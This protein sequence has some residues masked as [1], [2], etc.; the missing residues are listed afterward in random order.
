MLGEVYLFL[1]IAG[2]VVEMLLSIHLARADDL[3][4]GSLQRE[5]D[6]A[7]FL[8]LELRALAPGG[9]LLHGFD[10]GLAGG[11]GFVALASKDDLVILGLQSEIEL[12]I[13][14]ALIDFEHDPG[15]CVIYCW[16]VKS[17]LFRISC[18]TH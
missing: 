4:I 13:L 14:G 9:V 6:L 11:L 10:S 12:L 5:V 7:V 18:M 3:A 15:N 8:P 1:K 16:L 17:A 2:C